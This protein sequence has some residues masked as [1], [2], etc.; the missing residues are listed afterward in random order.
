MKQLFLLASLMLLSLSTS[1]A[2]QAQ[3]SAG[4]QLIIFDTDMGNDI[5]DALALDLLYKYQDKGKIKILSIM[6]NK[7]GE[8]PARYVDIMN[9]WYG[10][11]NIPIGIAR[12]GAD[13]EEMNNY[14]QKVSDMKVDGK[15]V[16]KT[17][18]PDVTKLPDAEQLYRKVLAKQPDHSVIII[19]TGFSTNLARLFDTKGD[20]NSPLTGLQLVKKKVKYM[21][22]MAGQFYGSRKEFNVIKDIPACAQV[23]AQSPVPIVTSPFDVGKAIM[24]PGKS[25]ENDFTWAKYHP[26]V[27]GYKAYMKMPYDRPSWDVTSVLQVVEPGFMTESERGNIFVDPQGRTYFSKSFDGLHTYLSVTPEQAQKVKDFFV[28]VIPQQPKNWKK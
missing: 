26:M 23:F 22:L 28:K 8:G 21:S 7:V 4:T 9:T 13:C 10:Y 24:Y 5:D 25:I 6:V 11:P 1:I 2:V 12:T 18:V 14:A 3:R 20:A 15:P 19:S 17:T 16:F 27:E